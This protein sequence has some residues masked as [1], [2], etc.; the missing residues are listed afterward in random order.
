MRHGILSLML[1]LT[2]SLQGCFPIVATGV[3]SGA[4]MAADR[5]SSGIYIEDEAIENR[6]LSSIGAAYKE[7]VHVNVTSFNRNVLVTGEVPDAATKKAIGKIAG[8]TENVNHMYNELSIE[9]PRSLTS[10]SNDA[11][12]TSKVKF[13]FTSSKQFSA[14]HVKVVTENRTVYLLGIVTRAEADAASEIAS[15]TSG[16]YKVV[17][18]FEYLD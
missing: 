9:L 4:L 7:D 5:R 8:A 14:N 11:L 6:A 15:T 2:V 18:V 10:R 13:N 12:I 17:R 16:V 3:G 1:L